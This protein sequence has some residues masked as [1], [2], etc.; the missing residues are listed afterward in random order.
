MPANEA[1]ELQR[2]LE[3]VTAERDEFETKIEAAEETIAELREALAELRPIAE[4]AA[5]SDLRA[6]WILE[7]AAELGGA[8]C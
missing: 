7:R 4:H 2:D 5:G 6:R 8:P 1:A 3:A